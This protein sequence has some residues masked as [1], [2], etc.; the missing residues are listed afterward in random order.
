MKTPLD[1]ETWQLATDVL[2]RARRSGV[3]PVEALYKA[4][5]LATAATDRALQADAVE[6]VE[7]HLR[8]HRVADVLRA[9]FKNNLKRATLQD[10]Y[11]CIVEWLEQYGK[12]LRKP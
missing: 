9:K 5:L 2:A 10:L 7:L 6:A 11:D 4:G 1:A 12:D 8:S 3:D